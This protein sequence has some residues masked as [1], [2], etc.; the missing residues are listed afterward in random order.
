VV[1]IVCPNNDRGTYTLTYVQLFADGGGT[2]TLQANVL[3]DGTSASPTEVEYDMTV[4]TGSNYQITVCP[5]DEVA[6]Q[7]CGWFPLVTPTTSWCT[8]YTP[9]PRHGGMQSSGGCKTPCE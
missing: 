6:W 4:A 3:D 8:A 5:S 9:P 1:A 7:G 2:A